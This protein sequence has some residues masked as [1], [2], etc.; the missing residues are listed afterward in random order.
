MNI[1]F[2]SA[3]FCILAGL[4]VQCSISN[5]TKSIEDLRTAFN[6]E[7]TA[8]LK[9][10]KF[11]QVAQSEGLDTISKLFDAVSESSNIMA[12]NHR[13]ALEILGSRPG[14]AEIGSF[15][16]KTTLENLQSAINGEAYEVQTS[17]PKFIRDAEN[18]KAPQ[19][20]KSFTWAWDTG[21]KHLTYLRR[22]AASLA[23]GN[24]TGLPLT[25]YLC[26]VCGNTY[27]SLDVKP[28]C[29][30]CLSKQESFIGYVQ[31]SE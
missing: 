18:E 16:V 2:R 6:N 11:A 21:K 13:K 10:S 8:S 25:W 28:M 22:S 19:A 27:N 14:F 15:D 31:A 23:K 12:N 30:F 5:P 9:Y 1:I 3:I 20:G 17:Y 29:D 24:S 26:P 7:S 4:L